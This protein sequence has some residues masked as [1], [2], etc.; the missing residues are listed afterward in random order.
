MVQLLGIVS[1]TFCNSATHDRKKL[2]TK[3]LRSLLIFN[4]KSALSGAKGNAYASGADHMKLIVNN[5]NGFPNPKRIGEYRDGTYMMK[6][7]E[8]MIR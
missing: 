1:R 6:Y 3:R 7:N 5:L 8:I 4:F 2:D